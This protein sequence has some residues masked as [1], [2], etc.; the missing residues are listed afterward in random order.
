MEAQELLIL[1]IIVKSVITMVTWP[2]NVFG[3]SKM[4]ETEVEDDKVME[5]IVEVEVLFMVEEIL[6][7]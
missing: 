2:Q 4:E 7:V 5:E 1:I 6:E 3:D